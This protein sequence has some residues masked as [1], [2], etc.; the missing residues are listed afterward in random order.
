MYS[1]ILFLLTC[2]YPG[3]KNSDYT[4]EAV[5][6]DGKPEDSIYNSDVIT[7]AMQ[8]DAYLPLLS[9]KR[10]ALVVNQ[11]SMIDNTHLVDSLV[12]RGVRIEKIFAPEHG[13]R[14]NYDDGAAVKNSI[15]PATGIAIISLYGNNKKPT[16]EQLKDI[17]MV[18][19]DI[20][21]VGVRFYTF[22]ST[23]HYAMEACAEN[24]IPLLLLDRPNPNG[25]YVDGPVLKSA[26]RS[27]VGMHPIPV[28]HGMTLGELAQMIN[29]EGWLT[30]GVHC[31]L[32]IIPCKNYDHHTKYQLPVNPSPN[33]RSMESIYLYPSLCFFEGTAVSVGRGT[34]HPFQVIGSPWYPATG[35]AFIPQSSFGSA[36]PPFQGERCNGF[37][38]TGMTAAMLIQQKFTLSYLLNM[39]SGFTDK[40]KFFLPGGFFNKLAGTDE[41]RLQLEAGLTEEE[42]RIS[43]QDDLTAFRK[44]R[45][46]YVLYPD[47]E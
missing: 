43:W 39:Y 44:M 11:T 8:T 16:A 2:L 17:D 6:P 28:V 23:M 18:V 13:F 1:L 30:N 45:K 24:D 3:C 41:L 47:F 29:A 20:Q 14:G 25:F 15:D 42:I 26:F 40:E 31:D 7:G 9:G 27:F 46:Q 32:Q 12:H 22:L 5:H 35:F 21:D 37:D 4:P 34:D 38:L 10:I 19:F 36:S 33:L